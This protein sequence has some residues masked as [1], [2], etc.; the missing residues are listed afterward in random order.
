MAEL[1][2]DEWM[3]TFQGIWNADPGLKDALAEIGF[4][5]VIL[6]IRFEWFSLASVFPILILILLAAIRWLL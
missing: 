1:F 4:N 5:S 6:Q 2:D 3:K